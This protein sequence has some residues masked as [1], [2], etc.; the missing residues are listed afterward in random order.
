MVYIVE[1]ESH[2]LNEFFYKNS[3]QQNYSCYSDYSCSK[4][5][6]SV[7]YIVEH[8]SHELNEFFYKNLRQQNYSCYSD[9]SCSKK[10]RSVV[11]VVEHESHELNEFFIKLATAKLFVLFGLFVFKKDIRGF[12][13]KDPLS[14]LKSK[15]FDHYF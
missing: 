9:Y 1:H 13:S 4:K 2:E 6:R 11:Y 10:L 15:Y 7:V 3:R 5:L 8:E 14:M 12:R